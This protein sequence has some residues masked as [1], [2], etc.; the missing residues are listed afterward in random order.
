[1]KWKDQIF[2]WTAQDYADIYKKQFGYVPDYHPPQSTA[3]L[4]VY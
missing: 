3:A 4:E 1:M 2:G